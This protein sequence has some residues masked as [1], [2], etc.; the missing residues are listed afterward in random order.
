MN[1]YVMSWLGMCVLLTQ[2]TIAASEDEPPKV[3]EIK[4]AHAVLTYLDGQRE[5]IQVEQGQRF[6]VQRRLDTYYVIEH[7]ARRAIVAI[8]DVIPAKTPQPE[9]RWEYVVTTAQAPIAIKRG[10]R[11]L[12]DTV[13]Q[14]EVLEVL[15]RNTLGATLYV[16][17]K[18]GRTAEI[19]QEL[20]RPARDREQPPPPPVGIVPGPVRLGCEISIDEQRNVYVEYVYPG[21]LAERIGL[22]PLTR[23]LEVNG[24]EIH[25]AADYDRA[26]QLLGGNLRLLVRRYRM[27]YPEM[28]EY[29]DPRN[30]Q[31][32]APQPR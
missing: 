26:S 24:E 3:V 23:I 27:Q 32:N 16:L 1:R 10:R 31:R 19:S 5:Q 21:S 13:A 28:L 4:S 8:R 15:G 11:S 6:P 18:G 30:P 20:V 17:I 25:S 22:Q 2:S 7:E 14:G 29:W 9:A 12:P